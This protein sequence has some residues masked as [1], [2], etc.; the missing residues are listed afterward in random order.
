[1]TTTDKT[2]D[3]L[4]ASIRR[5]KANAAKPTDAAAK[6]AASAA[7]SG[8]AKRAPRRRTSAGNGDAASAI[9]AVTQQASTDPFQSRGRIWPD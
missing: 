7:A 4:V 1:M 3:K 5:T 2:G 8:P 9:A 6:P